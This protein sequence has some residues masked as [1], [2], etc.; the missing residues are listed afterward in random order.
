MNGSPARWWV[1]EHLAPGTAAPR[2]CRGFDV[3]G[4]VDVDALRAA[5]LAVLSAHEPLRTTVTDVDA[6]PVPVTA[7]ADPASF[8]VLDAPAT[9]AWEG[10]PARLTLTRTGPD[11]HRVT[12]VLHRT[13]ADDDTMDLVVE[14]LS[15]R[16]A[17]LVPP[18]PTA[19]S[20]GP[21]PRRD[22]ELLRWWQ[23]TARPTPP[24]SHPLGPDRDTT[25]VVPGGAAGFD[26]G[27]EAAA[28]VT[29]FARD[30]GTTP[31]AVLL[32]ALQS[33]L[34]RYDGGDLVTVGTPV[35]VRPAGAPRVA[36]AFDN[37]LVLPGDL[38]GA[39]TF[40]ARVLRAA[41]TTDACLAH[42]ELP[43]GELLRA[44]DAYGDARPVPLCDAVLV[45]R[46]APEAVLRLP[47]AEVRPA[48]ADTGW[49]TCDLT[50]TATVDPAAGLAGTLGFRGEEQRPAAAAVLEQLRTLLLAAITDPDA[51]AATLPMDAATPG[52]LASPAASD[53]LAVA[54]PAAVPGGPAPADRFADAPLVHEAVRAVS[55][56]T[57]A[58]VAVATEGSSLGYGDLERSVA[59]VAAHLRAAGAGG[60]AVAVRM[61]PGPRQIVASL[62]AL[63]AGGHLLWFGT[64]DAGERGRTALRELRPA[65]LLVDGGAETDAL[66]G[67][68]RAEIHGLVLDVGSL[69]AD[70]PP[71]APAAPVV[72][73]EAIAYVAYTSGSTGKPKG[74]AQTHGAFAQFAAWMATTFDLRPGARVAHWVAPEHDPSLYEA[75]ATL[76]AGATLCPVPQRVRVHPERFTDWLATERITFLQTV[77]SFAKELL[78]PMTAAA[79]RLGALR[80]LVLM[81]E[82]LPAALADGLRAALPGL[83]LSNVYGPTETVAATWAAIDAPVRGMA[84]IGRAIPGR[85]VLVL[86]EAD[87][88]CPDGVTGEVVIRSP[89]VADGY[90][91][92]PPGPA[93]RP[94][95]GM[96]PGTGVY[97]TGD[98]ARRRHDGRLEFRGRK[99]FQ[100]KLLGNRIEVA[101]VEEALAQHESVAECAVVPATDGDGLVVGL[102]AHVVPAPGADPAVAAWRAH[103]RRRFGAAL[104]LVQFEPMTGPLPRNVAG[105][106]D[107]SRL[108]ARQGQG[109][110]EATADRPWTWAET[111]VAQLWQD[112]LGAPP[113]G[114]GAS[115]TAAGAGSLDAL[116]LAGLIRKRFG[117]DVPL[118]QCLTNPTLTGLATA[119]VA[120]GARQDVAAGHLPPRPHRTEGECVESAD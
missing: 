97:R 7:A 89:Y 59:V 58:T 67:W 69:T 30:T 44:L 18:A 110:R 71:G 54:G 41:A 2:V 112:V 46:E 19:P 83:R 116:R 5:W 78:A 26:W 38:A 21:D 84:P 22:A 102:V 113:A 94:L 91:G 108:P 107:R 101:E 87:R 15:Q 9:P 81:G 42:R 77:P 53:S 74:I 33:L 82:A 103:L 76:T 34:C 48:P 55:D 4:P 93:F 40:R 68:Y 27:P 3:S 117:A 13:V 35:S 115:F 28:A 60:R 6:S 64:G 14:E 72:R 50:L 120:A 56:R 90:V 119:I 43:Y 79:G 86:D 104:V 57:P 75:F 51:D 8:A 1:L 106:V 100:V 16:C 109:G 25:P 88:P 17:G 92:L 31:F 105:K 65:C 39:D 52:P 61:A 99:D 49:A 62:A 11:R 66:A 47:G 29:G 85:E 98:L 96:D 20:T 23:G 24:V 10:L 118:Q 95:E 70:P 12:V 36:G 114:P 37:L 73:R 32:A 45:V 80:H 63:R 111:A